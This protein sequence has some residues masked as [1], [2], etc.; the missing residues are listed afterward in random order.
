MKTYSETRGVAVA[1][2]TATAIS[3]AAG[4]CKSTCVFSLLAPP[5]DDKAVSGAS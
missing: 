5:A 2:T 1:L 3:V 4:T